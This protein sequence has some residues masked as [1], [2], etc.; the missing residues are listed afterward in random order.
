LGSLST[1]NCPLDSG[2]ILSTG[3]NE[4]FVIIRPN[5]GS[6]VFRMS[7]IFSRS[8]FI[9]EWVSVN[10]DETV[11]ITGGD[12]F[13]IFGHGARVDV[14]AIAAW[15]EDTLNVPSKLA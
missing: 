14:G 2:L 7:S 3:G 15:W 1:F 5:D 13:L 10:A 12:E 8:V 4:I 6:D 11:I 9:E